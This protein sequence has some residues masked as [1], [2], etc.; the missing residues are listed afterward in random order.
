MVRPSSRRSATQCST[1]RDKPTQPSGSLRCLQGATSLLW[2]LATLSIAG[3]TREPVAAGWAGYAE[4]EYVYVSSA[5][6][7]TLATVAVH[8]GDQVAA[9]TALFSLE[10]DNRSAALAEADARLAAA[11][12][13][14]ADT[15]TGKR[16]DELAVLK[17]QLA[18]ARA[19]ASRA[20]TELKRQQALVAQE[21]VSRSRLD[22]ARTA[23]RQARDKVAEIQ[24][25]LRVAELPARRDEQAAARASAEAARQVQAQAQWRTQQGTVSAPAAGL[26]ADTF[27]RA[28]EF[29]AAGQ[30]VLALLPPAARKARFFVSEGELGSLAVGQSVSIR[31][32]GCGAPIAAQISF[33]SPKAEYTPPVIYSNVQR[34]KLVFMIEA[35]PRPGD[36]TRLHPGQPLD[37]QT[38]VAP[39][40]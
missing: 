14:A 11:R 32:D 30:P 8:A 12:A 13:Q 19:Q 22:D 40:G 17:A 3:C 24:A 23:A 28:G 5:V 33:I 25:S 39:S 38:R 36:A 15:T 2:V 10:D 37:V 27:Y 6:A 4:G 35:L 21:F 18:Q 9:G 7:G 34:A 1:A 20:D 29:V 16:S 26:I 31:C